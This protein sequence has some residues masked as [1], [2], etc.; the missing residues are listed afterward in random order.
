MIQVNGTVKHHAGRFNINLQ[1]TGA[2]EPQNIALHISVRWNDPS[3]PQPVI[4]R[5]SSQYGSWG[6]EE[7]HVPHFPFQHGQTFQML[8]L[9]EHNE[10]KVAVNGQ[11]LFSFNHRTP[12]HEVNHVGVTGDVQIQSINSF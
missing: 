3:S 2:T 12:L 1:S 6:N 10:W 4:I 9:A 7:R 11:H 8:I 5:N